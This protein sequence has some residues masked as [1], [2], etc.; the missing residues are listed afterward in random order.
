LTAKSGV[1]HDPEDCQGPPKNV[2][3]VG[4]KLDMIKED[5]SLRKVTFDEALNLARKLNLIS[6]IETSS[7]DTQRVDLI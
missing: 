4:T 5:E 2:I 7:K 1:K 3:L 6:V